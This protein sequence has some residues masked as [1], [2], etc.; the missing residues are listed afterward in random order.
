MHPVAY[1]VVAEID[2]ES[3]AAEFVEWLL[4][5]H[6]QAVMRHGARSCTVGREVA[7]GQG[8]IR[9]ASRYVFESA[10]ALARYEQ[11][12]APALRAEGERRFGA[13]RGVRISRRVIELL[14]EGQAGERS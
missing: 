1:E 11:A 5:G 3:T 14:W 2:D 7:R 6:V 9:I 12:W 13:G 4:G 8:P 10:E